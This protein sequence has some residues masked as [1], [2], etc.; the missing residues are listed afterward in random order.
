MADQGIMVGGESGT[1]NRAT[2]SRSGRKVPTKPRTGFDCRT[3]AGRFVNY[4]A[5]RWLGMVKRDPSDPIVQADVIAAAELSVRCDQMRAD[6][7]CNPA[8]LVQMENMLFRR[9]RALGIVEKLQDS[10]RTDQT[11]RP[12]VRLADYLAGRPL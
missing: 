12:R 1:I 9:L 5:A 7:K 6:Q 3:A 10:P 4:R 8:I 2:G 11:K